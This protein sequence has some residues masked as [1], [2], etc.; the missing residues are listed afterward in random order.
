MKNEDPGT[1][2]DLEP[3]AVILSLSKG[4]IL[5]VPVDLDPPI[6][7]LFYPWLRQEGISDNP[8]PGPFEL[9][10]RRAPCF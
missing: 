4:S 10:D 6:M 8:I 5:H 9:S 3:R 2:K 7:I 1:K